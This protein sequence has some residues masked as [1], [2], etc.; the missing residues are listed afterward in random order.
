MLSIENFIRIMKKR[1]VTP[2]LSHLRNKIYGFASQF[3]AF[4]G[5]SPL[6]SRYFITSIPQ[7]VSQHTE[8]VHYH[9]TEFRVSVYSCLSSSLC[10]NFLKMLFNIS[11]SIVWK[12][13]KDLYMGFC[14]F[15]SNEDGS[16]FKHY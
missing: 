3:F 5:L 14:N 11:V 15:V 12:Y 1:A 10:T 9:T 13:S 16:S 8:T 6:F 2:F 4:I 7:V